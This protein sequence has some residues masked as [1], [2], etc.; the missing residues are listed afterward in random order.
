VDRRSFFKTV[1][2]KVTKSAVKVV[3]SQVNKRASHWIRPPYA[4]NELDFILACT[5]CDKCVEACPHGV[6]FKLPSRLGARVM[7]TP[8]LDLINKG[9]H[10]CDDWPCVV[11]CEPG[12][13]KIP[14]IAEDEVQDLPILSRAEINTDSCLPYSGPECGACEASC[15]VPGALKWD[16]TRPLIDPEHCTGCGLCREICIVD[17]SAVIIHSLHHQQESHAIV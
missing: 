5:R 2:S 4:L 13:L 8:A 11:A 10:L 12:A 17:P 6:I 14:E 16:M 7:G 9:C 1:T 15:P 3:D